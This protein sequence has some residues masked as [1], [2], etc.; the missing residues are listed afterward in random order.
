M[1]TRPIQFTGMEERH[2]PNSELLPVSEGLDK[3][4]L[5]VGT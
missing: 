3:G 4:A 1:V 5:H 2:T